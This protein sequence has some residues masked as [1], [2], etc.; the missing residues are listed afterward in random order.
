MNFHCS[1]IFSESAS[2]AENK[3]Q[4]IVMAN[5][6]DTSVYTTVVPEMYGRHFVDPN[7][8]LTFY[9]E[10]FSQDKENSVTANNK[11]QLEANEKALDKFMKD[12]DEFIEQLAFRIETGVVFFHGNEVEFLKEAKRVDPYFLWANLEIGEV[13]SYASWSDNCYSCKTDDNIYFSSFNIENKAVDELWGIILDKDKM[14]KTCK[15]SL[16]YCDNEIWYH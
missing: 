4:V 2:F 1:E 14:C 6:V 13:M 5:I 15:N 3:I 9:G 7:G 11:R 16:L 8:P 12:Y 10:D